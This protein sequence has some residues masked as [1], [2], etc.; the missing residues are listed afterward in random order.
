MIPIQPATPDANFGFVLS[1]DL[2]DAVFVNADW[3]ALERPDASFNWT[4]FDNAAARAADAGKLVSLGVSLGTA[5][6]SFLYDAG[7]R[8]LTFVVDQP[9]APDF[10]DALPIPIPWDPVYVSRLKRLVTAMG[11]RYSA[12]PAVAA[13]KLAVV[14]KRTDETKLPNGVGET[15]TGLDGGLCV[16]TDDVAAWRDAGYTRAKVRQAFFD[17]AD[18]YA[19]AF[20]RQELQL[21][22]ST[23]AFPPLDET[24]STIPLTTFDRILT[25]ELVDGSRARYG[26]RFV[27]Q[28]NGLQGPRQNF[29]FYVRDA[30]RSAGGFG[31]QMAWYVTGDGTC[32]MNG[33]S[34]PCDAG[35]VL[36]QASDWAVDAGAS[37]LEFYMA[38][39]KNPA[40]NEVFVRAHQGL[41]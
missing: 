38:D 36:A 6:P 19:S 23:S 39:L 9:Y 17:V 37:Y 1:H 34:S 24:G 18:V 15:V 25:D 40:L 28:Y 33:K 27:V 12:A 35:A 21:M 30:G 31:Y 5:T 22:L 26:A 7:V 32:R 2:T 11:G 29:D 10:C 14:H 4:F 16:I 3:E 20:P 13:V 8:S 41:R